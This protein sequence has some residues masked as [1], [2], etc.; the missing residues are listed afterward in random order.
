M[1]QSSKFG[2]E[3]LDVWQRAV[4][5]PTLIIAM[6][7][8]L[9]TPRKHYRLI[10][11]LEASST[12]VAMNIAEGKGRY[13]QKEFVH[14]LYIARG[15]LYETLTLLEVFLRQGWISE[16]R[17]AELKEEAGTIARMLNA[18]IN[19]IKSNYQR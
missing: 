7:D 11:Q 14:Y 5:W 13:S 8:E 15:S 17:F 1:S 12:S 19:S 4:D 6:V 18:L 10:E 3:E 2:Y 16:S 9:Q